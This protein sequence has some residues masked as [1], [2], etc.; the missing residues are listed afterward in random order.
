[1]GARL[2]MLEAEERK[3]QQ[4]LDSLNAELVLIKMEIAQIKG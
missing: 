3:V 4:E 2:T 1:M